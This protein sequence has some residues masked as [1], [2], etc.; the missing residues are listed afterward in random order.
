MPGDRYEDYYAAKLWQLV[1][2]VYRAL[3]SDPVA[4]GPLAEIVARIGA[5]AAVLRRSL[6]RLWEDQSIETCDDWIIPGH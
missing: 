2:G 1:P 6:D 5:Q 4:P 3:D